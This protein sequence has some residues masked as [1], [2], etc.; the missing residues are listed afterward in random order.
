LLDSDLSD[1]FASSKRV[2]IY[3][4]GGVV[5]PASAP[6]ALALAPPLV[7]IVLAMTTRQVLVSLYAGVWT[8]ALITASW[9]PIAAT[10]LSLEWIVETVRDPFNATF[11]VLILLMG[12][13]AAF[14]YKS[15]SVLAL[16]QWVGDRVETARDAQVLT[17]LI[18]VF[19][20]FDSYT[21]TIITGNATKELSNA[22]C[23]SRE[24]HA[25]VLDS[26]TSPVTTFGPISNWIGFQVS[27]I[28]QVLAAGSLTVA[29]I[30]ATPYE[31][32]LRSIPWNIYCLMAFLMVGFIAIT[33]RF[34]GPMLDAE[35]RARSERQTMREG[36]TPL[37]NVTSDVGEPSERNPTLLNFF[38]PVIALVAVGLV[39]MWWLG[40]GAAPDVG[41]AQAFQETDIA[42]ALLFAAFAFAVTGFA[43]SVAVGALDLD[44]ASDTVVNGFKTMMVAVAI[45]VLAWSIG[46][47]AGEVGT[48]E[49]IVGV[50]TGSGLPG[51]TLPILIF[52]I[53]AFIA[54]TTGTSWGTMSIVTP[55]AIPLGFRVV[56]P[57][58][59][60]VLLGALLGGAIMG[61]HCSPISD[62]TVMSSIFAGSDHI[63]HVNTQIPFAL[64]AAGVAISMYGLYALGISTPLLILP[65]ALA[66]TLVVVT[67]LN[68]FDAR[69]KGLPEVI[70]TVEELE[71]GG[72]DVRTER[73]QDREGIL[74]RP[75]VGFDVV[76]AI[77]VFAI[78]VTAGYLA[79][80]LALS[81]FG[82]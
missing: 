36:A 45:I 52:L 72:V 73:S 23:S 60:P 79:S 47:A 27:V 29:A 51:Q 68:K 22:R 75:T 55:I 81:M 26:T 53:S 64:T 40:G 9:N 30:G 48:A 34:Y 82:A 7:A 80:I 39:S 62:T 61:D 18:G 6:T 66:V 69:R 1:D 63:D 17:W 24:M 28:A 4:E 32:F 10:A 11:L 43:G 65:T 8:G 38:A 49:Y 50:V 57:E 44:T 3:H 54:F 25:Y 33:Q 35:W 78:I 20:F 13:G 12:A 70:P 31:L 67:L 15:G 56:G 77:S 42:L 14:M 74:S 59:L 2:N 41:L 19:I 71:Q 21:S 76:N 37:S 46:L 58:I 5:M 16:E